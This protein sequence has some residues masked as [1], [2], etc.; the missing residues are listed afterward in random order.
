[1]GSFQHQG[2]YSAMR[3]TDYSI[4]V[5]CGRKSKKRSLLRLAVLTDASPA[6]LFR[7]QRRCTAAQRDVH[8]INMR[9]Q[10]VS[11]ASLNLNRFSEHECLQL[12]RFRSREIPKVVSLMEWTS[13][14]TKRSR[15]RCDPITACCVVLRK[16]STP[17]RWFDV[18]ILFGMR[19][20]ALSEVFWEVLEAFT[21]SK[22]NILDYSSELMQGRAATYAEAI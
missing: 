13:G 3:Q 9:S 11:A 15:Y 18:E 16:M 21:S 5:A 8:K 22:G 12:F 6:S 2:A 14:K 19:S 20:S 7:L 17:C 10:N 4:D 1:M